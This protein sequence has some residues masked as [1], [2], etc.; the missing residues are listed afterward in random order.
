MK[1]RKTF[2]T[3][4][5]FVIILFPNIAPAQTDYVVRLNGDTLKGSLQIYDYQQI[6]RVQI[7]TNETKTILTALQVKSISKKNEFYKPIRYDNTV[8]FM[9]V[10]INGYLSL[11]AF[12]LN[13]GAWDGRYLTKMDGTGME[14]PNLSFKKALGNY[15]SDCGDA[16]NK[17]ENGELGKRDLEKIVEL[18]N[19]CMMAKTVVVKP[20]VTSTSTP[21]PPS[22]T[23]SEK[24]LAVKNLQAKVET[25]N[26]S[27]KKDA[28]DVLKDIQSKVSKNESV[29]NYLID[30]LK[31][32][33]ADAPSL[34][35]DL[36]AVVI[37]LKK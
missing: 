20:N 7:K 15:L 35:K 25:E 23:D 31:S 30:G 1:S 10:L 37:L 28:L 26:F 19:A 22:S 14:V 18:Y 12:N 34:A 29:P 6:D 2:F 24:V 13:Q 33:L 11:T 8:R 16:K 5:V 32:T 21:T 4:A 36:D 27:T 17:I 3:T 9:K